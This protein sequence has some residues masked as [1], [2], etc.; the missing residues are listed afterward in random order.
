M[1]NLFK[2][3]FIK[4]YNNVENPI[5]RATYGIVAGVFGIICNVILFGIKLIAGI[6]SGSVAVIADA[7]NN[8]SDFMTSIITLVGFKMSK[9]PADKE[10]PYGHARFE[11]ITGLLVACIIFF[12]GIETGRASIEKIFGSGETDFSIITLCVLGV[13]IIVKLIM[14]FVYKGLGKTINSDAL[15]AMSTDSIN[16]VMATSVVLICTCIGMFSNVMLDG[17]FGVV[18]SLF[19]MIS[20]ISLLK[21]TINPLVGVSPD[22]ELVE[23]IR[24]KFKNYTQILDIHDL[25]VH[26]YGPTKTFAT[27]HIEVDASVDVMISHDLADNVERDFLKD[28]GVSLVCHID[29]VK[30]GDKETN[31]LK[32]A[33][34][35]ILTEFDKR[36]SVHDFRVVVG[37]THTNIIFDVVIPFDSEGYEYEIKKMVNE[38]LMHYE[39]KYYAVI[40]F[41]REYN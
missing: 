7:I 1:V 38:K 19:V 33:I 9:M 5:V 16:D 2:K 3:L 28:L 6:L 24:A 25:I 13:A 4:N 26:N 20:A 32:D 23:K 17:Y 10:H 35:K 18:V 27:V 30:V 41:D 36:I 39:K 31:E 34:T 14:S 29:P 40:E 37:N 21:D 8:L 12:I 11:Y 22:R 15:L